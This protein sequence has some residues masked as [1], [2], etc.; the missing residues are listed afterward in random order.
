MTLFSP[1]LKNL[2]F[3]CR[4]DFWQSQKWTIIIL[5]QLIPSFP[6]SPSDFWAE[7]LPPNSLFQ[8]KL[9]LNNL[10]HID[11]RFFLYQNF[12]R[13]MLC[14]GILDLGLRKHHHLKIMEKFLSWDLYSF[15]QKRK[16]GVGILSLTET[17]NSLPL[18]CPK[19]CFTFYLISSQ[20]WF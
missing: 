10:I 12:W 20:K 1:P 13:E 7:G 5:F 14:S 2:L 11:N 8:Q 9:P 17:K 6:P 3:W 15:F 18:L 16:V 4:F 19:I